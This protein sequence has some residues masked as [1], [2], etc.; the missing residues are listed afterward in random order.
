MKKVLVAVCLLLASAPL[1]TLHAQTSEPGCR[2]KIAT[3]KRGKG[4]AKLFND[5]QQVCGPQL[6]LCQLET[7]GGLQNITALS[8]NQVDVGFA[9]VDT[10]QDMKGSDENIATLQAVLPVNANLLHI[11]V[12]SEGFTVSAERTWST[13]FRREEKVRVIGKFSELRG[14]PVAVVGSAQLLV[15]KL[16]RE[17]AY[18]MKLV[19]VESDEHGIT[20]LKQ[21]DV[22]ALFSTSGWPHGTLSALTQEAGLTLVPYDLPAQTPYLIAHRNYANLGVFNQVFLAV[23]NLLVARPFRPDGPRGRDLAL[24]QRCVLSHLVTL[25]EGAFDPGWKEVK[26]PE[27]SYG[28]PKFVG[29][30]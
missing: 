2:L 23:P 28:W 3:G 6:P 11:V 13:L 26:D 15:R 5:L 7:T 17:L 12:R 4:F 8:A 29:A 22:A 19:D 18:G 21:G 20:L 25:Q 1:A 16:D 14:L 27:V 10:L 24:L 30:P 9:Q